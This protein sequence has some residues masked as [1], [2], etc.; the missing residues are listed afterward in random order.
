MKRKKKKKKI[1]SMDEAERFPILQKRNSKKE[2]EREKKKK[3][4][5]REKEKGKEKGKE[6]KKK[7]KTMADTGGMKKLKSC[8]KQTSRYGNYNE[9]DLDALFD[10]ASPSSILPILEDEILVINHDE[11]AEDDCVSHITTPSSLLPRPRRGGRRRNKIKVGPTADVI[12]S[13]DSSN[14]AGRQRCGKKKETNDKNNS[15]NNDDDIT[16]NKNKN[17]KK[18]KTKKEKKKISSDIKEG[19]KGNSSNDDHDNKDDTY[20]DMSSHPRVLRIVSNSS[21]E[22]NIVLQEGRRQHERTNKDRKQR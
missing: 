19:R 22:R 20:R 13:S 11:F 1:S 17:K 8:L 10:M 21:Q 14:K 6:K 5:G 15:N 4:K 9:T 18:T 2:N 3:K 7:V 12:A 16:K